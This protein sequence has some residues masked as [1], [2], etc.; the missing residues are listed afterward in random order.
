ME[1]KIK[2][3]DE[4]DLEF[5]KLYQEKYYKDNYINGF[6]FNIYDVVRISNDIAHD[7]GYAG[8]YGVV[9]GYSGDNY[10]YALAYDNRN[11][12]YWVCGFIER[13]LIKTNK[14]IK[15][16][17]GLYCNM[18]DYLIKNKFNLSTKHFKEM[19]HKY[20]NNKEIELIECKNIIY[21]DFK[22]GI[23]LKI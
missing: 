4:V 20:K 5:Y 3:L 23:K 9:I 11:N 12:R 1:S 22:N 15:D 19:W 7:K 17:E 16:I 2:K 10:F 14:N 8:Q 21:V 13:E 18:S 6:R